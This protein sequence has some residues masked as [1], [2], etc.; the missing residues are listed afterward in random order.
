M[1]RVLV[2]LGLGALLGLAACDSKPEAPAAPPAPKSMA[3]SQ[4]F[5][6]GQGLIEKVDTAS[7]SIASPGNLDML[8]AG[9]TAGP[10]YKNASFLPRINAAPP[11]DGVYEVDVV[12]DKPDGAAAAP[13]PIEVK[14]VWPYPVD[15]LKG[16]KFIAKSNSVVAMLPAKP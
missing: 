8:A 2:A 5:Y 16:V 15:H 10:G 11:V 3:R 4:Q 7:I 6:A 1:S 13:T 12:A 14:G 9:Q